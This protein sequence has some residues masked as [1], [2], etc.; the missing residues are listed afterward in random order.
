M[1]GYYKSAKA[2]SNPISYLSSIVILI[3]LVGSLWAV[4]SG[5]IR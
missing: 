1:V 5:L 3:F 2:R 4:I